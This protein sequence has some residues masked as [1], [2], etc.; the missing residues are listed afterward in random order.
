ME[1]RAVDRT[2]IQLEPVIAAA[3][4]QIAVDRTG[5]DDD[6][7]GTGTEGNRARDGACAPGRKGQ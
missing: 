4:A 7:V 1:D 2:A 5:I 6:R 3:F